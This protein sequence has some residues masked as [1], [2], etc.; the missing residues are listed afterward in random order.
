MAGGV[1]HPGENVVGE[2]GGRNRRRRAESA[3]I[4]RVFL[5]REQSGSGDEMRQ[6]GAVRPPRQVASSLSRALQMLSVASPEALRAC[7]RDR[8]SVRCGHSTEDEKSG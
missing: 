3:T 5:L 4:R 1:V 7:E 6:Q 2:A 8:Q